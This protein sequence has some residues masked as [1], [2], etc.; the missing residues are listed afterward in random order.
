MPK[1]YESTIFDPILF[2][3]GKNALSKT[4]LCLILNVS[5]PTL[6]KWIRK[7]GLIP[8]DKI[9]CLAGSFGMYPEE[10]VCILNRNK[11]QLNKELVWYMEGIK[12]RV[13]NSEVK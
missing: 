11:P 8:L 1:Y 2:Q 13:K 5:L 4:D 6:Q 7:P 10:L 3:M 12:Q 9:N